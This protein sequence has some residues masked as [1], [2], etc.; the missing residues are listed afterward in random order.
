MCEKVLVFLSNQFQVFIHRRSAESAYTGQLRHIHISRSEG[1]IVLIEYCRNVIL[2]GVRSADLLSF[3]LGVRHAGLDS[4]SDD[5]QFQFGKHCRHLDKGLTHGVYIAGS[6]VDG[7]T[8]EDFQT[9]MLRLDD[10]DDF[11]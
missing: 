10:V 11:S 7:D 8:S 5:G 3:A 6:A 2:G 1:G 4:G 9:Q